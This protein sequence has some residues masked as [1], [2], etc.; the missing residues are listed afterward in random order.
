MITTYSILDFWG[1]WHFTTLNYTSNYTLHP[2]LFKCTFCILNYDFYY[3]LHPNI[4]LLL[5]WMEKYDI[6]RKDLIDLFPML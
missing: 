5:T 3:T 6:T 4:N 1:K 2:K